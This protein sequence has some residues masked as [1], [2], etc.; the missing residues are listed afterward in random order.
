[1]ICGVDEA[2]RGPV[3]GPLVVAGVLVDEEGLGRLVEMGVRDSKRHTPVQRERLY[4]EITAAFRWRV[5]KIEPDELDSLMA[6]SSLNEIEADAFASVIE[7]LAPE[8]AYVD[9]AD[10]SCSSFASQILERLERR[11]QRLVVEHRADERYPVVS[12]AS[13]VAKVERDREIKRL[14]T[15]YGDFGSG[16]PS[17]EKTLHFLERYF[18]EHRQLPVCAR[19]RWK[20]AQRVSNQRLEDFY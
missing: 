20:T 9:A 10:I 18:R 19:K 4:R 15:V 5:L 7:G 11:P 17:D 2:G 3:I 6:R 13:I 14:H 1:M 8:T 12:A 16:Y